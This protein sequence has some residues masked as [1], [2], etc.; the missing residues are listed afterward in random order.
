[1]F[2]AAALPSVRKKEDEEG[3]PLRAACGNPATRDHHPLLRKW[4][5]PRGV[6]PAAKGRPK[7]HGSAP[8]AEVGL[9]EGRMGERLRRGGLGRDGEDEG[10]ER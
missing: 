1:M 8:E 3:I 10:A 5:L 9:W 7:G 4:L 6:K 2:W